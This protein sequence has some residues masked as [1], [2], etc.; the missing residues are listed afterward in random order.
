MSIAWAAHRDGVVSDPLRRDAPFLDE[1]VVER[2]GKLAVCAR[3]VI[4]LA[5]DGEDVPR[6]PSPGRSPRG[7]GWYQYA[8][9]SGT[10]RGR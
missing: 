3:P 2:H 1:D 6:G 7:C 5:R 8:P 9:G 4:V 10:P